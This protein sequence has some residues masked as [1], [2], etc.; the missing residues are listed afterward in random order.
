MHY[1]G[2][3]LIYSKINPEAA[4]T[5][6]PGAANSKFLLD[7]QMRNDDVKEI[8]ASGGWFVTDMASEKP[9]GV[10]LVMGAVGKL[11][12]TG[13]ANGKFSSST[14][15]CVMTSTKENGAYVCSLD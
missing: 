11:L 8:G 15:R 14:C 6:T 5:A 7:L 2:G 9:L 4:M 12:V 3:P 10:M 1:V 13:A